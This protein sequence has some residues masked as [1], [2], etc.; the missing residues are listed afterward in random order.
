[1]NIQRSTWGGLIAQTR[2]VGSRGRSPPLCVRGE[3]ST[4][5]DGAKSITFTPAISGTFAVATTS[6]HYPRAIPGGTITAATP[7]F[8]YNH[9]CHPPLFSTTS[10]PV[11]TPFLQ[12]TAGRPCT[13]C[14]P[15]PSHLHKPL[16]CPTLH[17]ALPGLVEFPSASP[18]HLPTDTGPLLLADAGAKA[19]AE[20]VPNNRVKEPH[21][22]FT[23]HHFKP[24]L[25]QH[26]C[27]HSPRT[28]AAAALCVCVRARARA[29]ACASYLWSVA[30]D[31]GHANDL[32]LAPS[33]SSL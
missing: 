19:I 33:S 7:F 22:V 17:P 13:T 14:G 10:S 20:V 30:Y 18:T 29:R 4:E 9:C 6:H 1:M 3:I 16:W 25:C 15:D 27:P 31:N 8:F 23:P 12:A 24:E 21:S 32:I 28:V 2:A 5:R 11:L 26:S